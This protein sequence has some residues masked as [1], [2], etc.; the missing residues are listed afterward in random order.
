MADL[1]SLPFEIHVLIVRN[2]CLRDCLSYAEVANVSHDAVYYV[3]AHR[4]ELNFS[5]LVENSYLTPL[6]DE[7]FLRILYS[8]TRA[9]RLRNFCVPISF[10]AFSAL[11]N[12]LN[13]YRSFTFISECDP[14]L[15]CTDTIC[16]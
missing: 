5:S 2:L 6:P 4:A 10:V 15:S 9:T 7:Q 8:H 11:S 3:F 12:Y 1:L 13:L 16:G 14:S